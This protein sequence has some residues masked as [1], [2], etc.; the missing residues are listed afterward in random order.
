[1]KRE[2]EDSIKGRE[3]ENNSTSKKV[4]IES[5]LDLNNLGAGYNS[6]DKKVVRAIEIYGTKLLPFIKENKTIFKNSNFLSI[7]GYGT[8][9]PI[10]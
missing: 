9:I 6:N 7:K 2:N 5:S 10:K 4:K 8:D 3:S 1:M